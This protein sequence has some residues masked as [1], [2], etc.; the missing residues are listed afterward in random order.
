MS[1]PRKPDVIDEE[2]YE[3]LSLVEKWRYL[4]ARMEEIDRRVRSL[5]NHEEKK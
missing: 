2:E 3:K 1:K 5:I 4:N